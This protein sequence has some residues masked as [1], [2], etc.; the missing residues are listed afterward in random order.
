LRRGRVADR[1]ANGRACTESLAKLA[2]RERAAGQ[3][4]K[5]ENAEDKKDEWTFAQFA[6]NNKSR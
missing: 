1:H 2:Q 4:R 6:T 3:K 5:T